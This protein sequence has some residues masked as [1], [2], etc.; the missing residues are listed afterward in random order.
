MSVGKRDALR[1][2]G[3]EGRGVPVPDLPV[4]T[5]DAGQGCCRICPTL[6]TQTVHPPFYIIK[7]GTVKQFALL[8]FY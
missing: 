3:K 4:F 1:P 7:R 8:P 5:S 6:K 2:G